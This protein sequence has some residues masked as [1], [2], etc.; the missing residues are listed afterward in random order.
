MYFWG[1]LLRPPSQGFFPPFSLQGPGSP[2]RQ[3]KEWSCRDDHGSQGF[4]TY[5]Q[6][7]K[8]CGRSMDF[9]G[10][11][12]VFIHI[13]FFPFLNWCKWVILWLLTFLQFLTPK[14]GR[15]AEAEVYFR[16]AQQGLSRQL[17]A[18]LGGGWQGSIPKPKMG[19][20]L[21]LIVARIDLKGMPLQK[22]SSWITRWWQLKYFWNF[23]PETWGR[24]T[25]FD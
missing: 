9:L 5:Y 8:P 10:V 11:H 17:G 12:I 14:P 3:N 1:W 24:W 13:Y 20:L 18:P 6:R 21:L 7:D 22:H 23:H 2:G 25:H 19:P 16:R 4:P 15:P